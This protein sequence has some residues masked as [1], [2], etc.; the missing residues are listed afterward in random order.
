MPQFT[1]EEVVTDQCEESSLIGKMCIPLKCSFLHE[2][3]QIDQ[4]GLWTCPKAQVWEDFFPLR[5]SIF[6]IVG[7]INSSLALFSFF[8]KGC[9]AFFGLAAISTYSNL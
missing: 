6:S 3:G 5:G 9:M 1:V 2:Y 4:Y 7:T 8:V